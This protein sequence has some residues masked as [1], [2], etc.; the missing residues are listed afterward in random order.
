MSPAGQRSVGS[1]PHRTPPQPQSFWSDW[2]TQ[3]WP[4]TR[5]LGRGWRG[6][7]PSGAAPTLTFSLVHPLP[8]PAGPPCQRG[9]GGWAEG[10]C[11]PGSPGHTPPLARKCPD[12]QPPS[13]KACRGPGP[14]LPPQHFEEQW[15]RKRAGGEPL[16]KTRMSSDP[17][18]HIPVFLPISQPCAHTLS[19][20]LS[21]GT[22]MTHQRCGR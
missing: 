16:G 8:P 10:C 3:K 20:H 6:T 18:E 2:S 21:P 17:A 19:G 14:Q 15:S 7:G 1:A 5:H 11:M 9:P 4:K 13:P 12:I 22:V